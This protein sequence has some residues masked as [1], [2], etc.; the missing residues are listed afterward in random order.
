ML[1]WPDV[2]AWFAF[3]GAV[4]WAFQR[5]TRWMTCLNIFSVFLAFLILRHGLTVP[6]D[7]TV[8]AWYAGIE[9]SPRAFQRYYTSL[10]LMW[11]CLLLGALIGRVFMGPARLS[12][13]AF[14]LEVRRAK[15]PAGINVLFPVVCLAVIGLI[16]AY[17]FRS[18]VSLTTLLSGRLTSEE[19]RAMRESFGAATLYSLG[20]GYRL[21]TIAR[22]GILPT[23]VSVLFFLARREWIWRALFVL[24]L[25]LGLIVGLLSGQK[26]ASLFLI[27]AVAIAAYYR[28]GRLRLR[29]ADWR[30]WGGLMAGIFGVMWLYSLQYPE[31][32]FSALWRATVYR[33]TSEADRSLQLYF[34]IYPD[35]Q[36]FLHGHS[37]TLIDSLLGVNMPA[38]QIPER[39]IPVY[40]LGDSYTDTWNGAF[41][42]VAWADFAYTGVVVESLFVGLL[43]YAYARWFSRAPKTALVMGTQVGLLMA[44]SRLS[45]VALSASLLTFG[46]G[47]SFV[48]YF[49]MRS[50]PR[51]RRKLLAEETPVVYAHSPG[52]T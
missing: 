6:F 47:S 13:A 5:L 20:A 9:V 41:I 18:D 3:L 8:N 1:P 28:M 37:S 45:E 7:H 23:L 49:A 2:L 50:P 16:V 27:M 40:Y 31:L 26:G 52:R 25:T 48:L 39:F 24:T 36:P 19:Y 30:I 21:A 42:G 32:S 46:L 4:L 38:D 15:L 10:V 12:P 35:V 44:S 22:F 51:R 14:R 43:L 17:D 33:L 34:Q 11:L 29:L